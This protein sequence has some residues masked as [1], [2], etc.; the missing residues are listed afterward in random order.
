MK[1]E[2]IEKSKNVNQDPQLREFYELL[3]TNTLTQSYQ[4]YLEIKNT[5]QI[6]NINQAD[7]V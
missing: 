3:Y 1:T 6:E 7:L 2:I 4:D 5:M